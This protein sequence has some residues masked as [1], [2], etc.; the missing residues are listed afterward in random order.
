MLNVCELIYEFFRNII[1]DKLQK[2][3]ILDVEQV[4]HSDFREARMGYEYF[5]IYTK[6]Y[7]SSRRLRETGSRVWQSGDRAGAFALQL[8]DH[9]GQSD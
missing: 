1:L 2:C 5:K 4:K 8:I 6:I 7:E 9:R 3:V